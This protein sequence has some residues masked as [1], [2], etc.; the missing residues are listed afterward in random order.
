MV[1]PIKPEDQY[2]TWRSDF[3]A[4]VQVFLASLAGE[5]MFFDNDNS[6]GVSGDLEAATLI[7]AQMEGLFGM[8]QT[9][10]SLSAG[11]R[12]QLGT[13]GGRGKGNQEEVEAVARRMLA[14]RV[15]DNLTRLLDQAVEVLRQNERYVLAIAHALETHKTIS[16]EDVTAIFEGQHGPLVDGSVYQDDAFLDRLREYH[17]SAKQAHHEHNR[18]LVALPVPRPEYAAVIP[19]SYL[20]DSYGSNGNGTNGSG[21]YGGPFSAPTYDPPPVDTPPGEEPP[22]P[23]E[24]GSPGDTDEH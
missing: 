2:T 8:G 17:L 11:Q 7:A 4:E 3:E 21:A 5:R 9:V 12:L 20:N 1:A 14:D 22:R 24:P 6:S 23:E 19:S 18:P 15:E 10:S 16:G 13:P